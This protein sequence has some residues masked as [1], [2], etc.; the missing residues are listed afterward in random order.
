MIDHNAVVVPYVAI[1]VLAVAARTAV[2]L[3]HRDLIQ[4]GFFLQLVTGLAGT[5][6]GVLYSSTWAATHFDHAIGIQ[7]VHVP[8]RELILII[9]S[10]TG[11]RVTMTWGRGHPPRQIAP[12]ALGIATVA[13]AAVLYTHGRH[14]DIT[15]SDDYP[16][17]AVYYAAFYLYNAYGCAQLIRFGTVVVKQFD[18]RS[19]SAVGLRALMTAAGIGIVFG[20]FHLVALAMICAGWETDVHHLLTIG[21]ALFMPV[22]LGYIL[23]T[24]YPTLAGAWG[25]RAG[26]QHP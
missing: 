12:I 7:G 16:V 6:V 1:S 20:A 22:D 4:R 13:I 11:Q 18:S 2:A 10:A 26:Y 17:V 9:A 24:S 25:R 19:A 8:V 21:D 23:S 3:R 5:V 15:L 14:L